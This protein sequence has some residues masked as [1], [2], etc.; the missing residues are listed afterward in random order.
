MLKFS[1]RKVELTQFAR[2]LEEEGYKIVSKERKLIKEGVITN[3]IIVE[4][5]KL[6][7]YFTPFKAELH[8]KTEDLSKKDT[9]LIEIIN[10]SYPSIIDFR[11]LIK[12]FIIGFIIGCAIMYAIAYL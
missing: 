11:E 6:R 2:R 10:E 4:S 5:E 7:G 8:T 9:K 1:F 3:K 12:T